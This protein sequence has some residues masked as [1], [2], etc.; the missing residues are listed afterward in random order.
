MARLESQPRSIQFAQSVG[1]IG[2]LSN[3][4]VSFIP[5]VAA[6]EPSWS[7]NRDRLAT[8]RKNQSCHP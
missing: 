4:I 5:D 6:S 8:L 3:S 2:S 1:S 7:S